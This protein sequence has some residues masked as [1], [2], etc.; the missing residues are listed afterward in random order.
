[1]RHVGKAGGTNNNNIDNKAKNNSNDTNS[2]D[3]RNDGSDNNK[4]GGDAKQG[5]GQRLALSSD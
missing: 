5:K 3:Q 2:N 1:M 4:I